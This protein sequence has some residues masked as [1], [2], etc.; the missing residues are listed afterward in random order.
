MTACGALGKVGKALGAKVAKRLL[1]AEKKK[2]VGVA[3]DDK[4]QADDAEDADV[5][6]NEPTR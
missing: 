4:S 1:R 3:A 6:S 5:E 2:T